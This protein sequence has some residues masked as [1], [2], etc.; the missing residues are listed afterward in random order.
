[1]PITSYVK[2]EH[3]LTI[4]VHRGAVSD[5]EFLAF[6]KQFFSGGRYDSSMNLLVDLRDADSTQRS[7]GV[8]R[9]FAG[10]MGTKIPGGTVRPKV[11]V[12][13]QKDLS[14]GLARMYEAFAESVPW[15]FVVFR[16]L[17]A[18]LA[19]LGLTDEVMSHVEQ[20]V[21]NNSDPGPTQ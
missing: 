2:P 14:F 8:L 5:D 3:K 16:A 21:Y 20:E 10:F 13:A 12:V 17:D 9:S 19:W 4:F 7:P 1:M 18:A 11:A 15:D 6:Y